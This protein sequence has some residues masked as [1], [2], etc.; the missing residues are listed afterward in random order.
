MPPRPLFVTEII[1]AAIEILQQ[2]QQRIEQTTSAGG[3]VDDR[4]SA[5]VLDLCKQILAADQQ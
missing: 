1:P 2:H 3:Y 4:E 5:H